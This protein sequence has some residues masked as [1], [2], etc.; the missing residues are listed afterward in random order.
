LKWF[1]PGECTGNLKASHSLHLGRPSAHL[2]GQLWFWLTLVP[3]SPLS[4][5]F[6]GVC[7][8]A[9]APVP[10]RLCSSF[11]PLYPHC[12]IKAHL[13]DRLMTSSYAA[14]QPDG[15]APLLW[16]TANGRAAL[17]FLRP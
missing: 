2:K 8:S 12:L 11:F 10:I 17:G 4:F 13:R 16:P 14:S 7:S 6:R 1:L 5:P 3:L 9:K 15:N